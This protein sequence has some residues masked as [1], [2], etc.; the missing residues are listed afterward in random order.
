MDA[1]AIIAALAVALQT[2]TEEEAPASLDDRL[3]IAVA[4]RKRLGEAAEA[5]SP[6]RLS[7]FQT[8]DSSTD[9]SP[10]TS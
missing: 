9:P 10:P 7:R 4:A 2:G 8:T 5:L 3:Q 1:D 6:F